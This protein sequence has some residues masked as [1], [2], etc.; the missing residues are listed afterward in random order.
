M[1]GRNET[2]SVHLAHILRICTSMQNSVGTPWVSWASATASGPI[3]QVA[4][5]E[6]SSCM[7]NNKKV[8]A[9]SDAHLV[10]VRV[11]SD[12]LTHHFCAGI[13]GAA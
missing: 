12:H 1:Q 3:W 2:T 6:A 11:L 10:C 8:L 7:H 13:G 5:A 9:C 4:G